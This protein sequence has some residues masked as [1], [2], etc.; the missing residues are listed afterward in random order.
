MSIFLEPISRF[1]ITTSTYI[2]QQLQH[3]VVV[4]SI[5]RSAVSSMKL[6]QSNSK[7]ATIFA[8]CL[9]NVCV[10]EAFTLSI[11]G[12][13][14]YRYMIRQQMR[15]QE[16]SATTP[17]FVNDDSKSSSTE[18]SA[19]LEGVVAGINLQHRTLG[20]QEHLMLPRQYSVGNEVFPQMSHVSCTVLNNTPSTVALK[21]AINSAMKS[22]PMLRAGV[23]GTGEPTER[24]DLFKMVRSGEPDPLTFQEMEVGHFAAENVLSIKNI[25]A[26]SGI[27]ADKSR[28]LLQDSWKERFN[29]DLDL[30]IMDVTEGPLWRI[31]LHRFGTDGDA[32]DDPCALLLTFNHAI[33]D[34]SSANLVMD[35]ILM[36]VAD[37]ESVGSIVNEGIENEM[38]RSLE[39][40]VLGTGQNWAG[41][42]P[43]GISFGTLKYVAGKAAE[44][45]KNPVILPDD[46]ST[47]GKSD[48][49]AA[50]TTITGRAAGGESASAGERRSTLQFRT[51]DA[52]VTLKLLQ[53]CRD[54]GV[55]MTNALSAAVTLSSTDFIAGG[56]ASTKERN[57][58]VLQSLD[59]RRF[60]SEP[61]KCESVSCQAGS[62]DLMLG[63]LKDYSGEALRLKG[64]DEVLTQFWKLAKEGKDQTKD[65]IESDGPK[66]A[67]RIFDFAM[68]IADLNNL[69]HLTAKSESSKGRAYSA[70]IS[71]VGVYERQQSVKR[72]G[73]SS[74]D[75]DTLKVF[76]LSLDYF[77]KYIP[78]TVLKFILLLHD[79]KQFRQ[80][81]ADIKSKIFSSPRVM[82]RVVVFTRSLV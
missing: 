61:D 17:Y 28:I 39:E 15:P 29:N 72:T 55:T 57:Y 68:T 52:D 11:K 6:L 14:G 49:L 58:K 63:P 75:R 8:L 71:N 60:G 31:E 67:V 3:I 54:N 35:E 26:E 41:I 81:T 78:D 33:S 65:F 5:I 12:A 16:T 19:S 1:A 36:D 23:T 44:G 40:N 62:M 25:V 56:V 18:T 64:G 80:R 22:H 82:R 59:M 69:V 76:I 46:D 48:P 9:A 47:E 38:P 2:P 79:A 73:D 4:D 45:L 13:N 50:I 27:D 70:G 51:L 74:G 43:G 34:Q 10:V 7:N 32:S 53:K 20:S 21:Q 37:I 66:H 30:A 24:I 77:L 42:G